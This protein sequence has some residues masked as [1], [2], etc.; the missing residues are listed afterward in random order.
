MMK[1]FQQNLV[2]VLKNSLL[3][4]LKQLMCFPLNL[5]YFVFLEIIVYKC[6]RK[7]VQDSPY[8]L[9]LFF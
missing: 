9:F 4:I 7:L 2:Y 1:E 8:F 3:Y 5:I 6:F